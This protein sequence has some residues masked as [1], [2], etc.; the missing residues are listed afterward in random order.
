MQ[1]SSIV[2]ASDGALL[3]SYGQSCKG[4]LDETNQ[5]FS[6]WAVRPTSEWRFISVGQAVVPVERR[7]VVAGVDVIAAAAVVVNKKIWGLVVRIK[8]AVAS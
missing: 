6:H 1:P 2:F 5:C 3:R 4:I 7:L 8:V